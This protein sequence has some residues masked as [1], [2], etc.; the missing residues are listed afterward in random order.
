MSR[1]YGHPVKKY[2]FYDPISDIVKVTLGTA[3]GTLVKEGCLLGKVYTTDAIVPYDP[4]GKPTASTSFS[5]EHMVVGVLLHADAAAGDQVDIAVRGTFGDVYAFVNMNQTLTT[6]GT[7]HDYVL[8]REVLEAE[9][10]IVAV[11][12]VAK[13]YGVHYTIGDGT[14]AD[15]SQIEFATATSTATGTIASIPTAGSTLT[16][17]YKGRFK[18]SDFWNSA[19]TI[20][21][22]PV[23]EFPA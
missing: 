22:R 5:G 19:P 2:A 3:C 9:T 13:T 15:T 16:I 12:S 17:W 23:L 18:T 6:S 1:F 8:A 10:T 14:A 20:V 7:A 11:N 4:D 21:V